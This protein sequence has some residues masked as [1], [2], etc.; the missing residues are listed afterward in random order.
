MVNNLENSDEGDVHVRQGVCKV[1]AVWRVLERACGGLECLEG[2]VV[3]ST[4][5]TTVNLLSAI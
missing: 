1:L 5:D 3:G 2:V 4:P